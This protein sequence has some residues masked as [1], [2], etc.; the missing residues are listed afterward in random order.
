[1]TKGAES[2]LLTKHSRV[3]QQLER[4]ASGRGSPATILRHAFMAALDPN[5]STMAKETYAALR[6]RFRNELISAPNGVRYR[7][8]ALQRDYVR[9]VLVERYVQ[10]KKTWDE[11]YQLTSEYVS[12]SRSK[13]LSPSTIPK[14]H[15][16]IKKLLKDEKMRKF[17]EGLEFEFQVALG[18]DPPVGSFV[19]PDFL[20][21]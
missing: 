9:Y 20:R 6:Y 4:I 7:L 17:L 14:T 8:P 13:P 3:V 12:A 18:Q 5:A 15:A 19:D 1:M 11:A 16:K 21:G 10:S 2:Y